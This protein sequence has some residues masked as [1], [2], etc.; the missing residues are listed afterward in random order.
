MLGNGL[1]IRQFYKGL[2]AALM[3]QFT[4][5]TPRMGIYKTLLYKYEQR[6]KEKVP[7]KYKALFGVTAGFFGSLC[8]NPA[9]LI[10]IRLQSDKA[11][12]KE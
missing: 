11:L 2:D 9:D 10:L 5:T 8:G 3:R 4:Y 12:P 1:G 7:L 6:N